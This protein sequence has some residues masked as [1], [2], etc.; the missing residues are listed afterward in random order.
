MNWVVTVLLGLGVFFFAIGTIGI[1]R[2]PDF[3]SR[4]HAAGKCDTLAVT[5]AVSAVAL[6]NLQDLSFA[7][8]L[9]SWKIFAIIFFIFMASPTATHAITKAAMLVGVEPWLKK[10]GPRK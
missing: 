7:S 9:V 6:Y 1:L 8:I 2:L 4:L 5:L 10:K 3:Y